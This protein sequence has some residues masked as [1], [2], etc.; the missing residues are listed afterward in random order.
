MKRWLIAATLV[1]S[2]AACAQVLASGAAVVNGVRISQSDVDDEVNAQQSGP[3]TPDGKIQIARQ[4]LGRLIQQQ[5]LLQEAARR[6]IVA[7]PAKVKE[8]FDQ[9]AGQFPTKKEFADRL[10]EFGLTEDSL[11]ARIRDSLMISEL[12]SRLTGTISNN[13]LLSI[14]RAE[15]SQYRQV[16]VKHILFAV[17]ERHP[18][19]AAHDAAIAAREKILAGASFATLA[20]KSDDTSS[21]ATGGALPG[22]TSLAQ[23]DP[24]FAEAAWTAKPGVVTRPVRSQFGWHLIVTTARRIQPFAEVKE[25]IRSQLEQQVTQT[26]QSNFLRAVVKR[27]EI[28]VNPRYGDWDPA[29]AS[30]VAHQSFVPPENSIDDNAPGG[31]SDQ[32]IPGATAPQ[33][34]GEIKK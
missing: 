22:W 11:R 2:T 28:I 16:R 7:N 21:R 14:Y 26:A 27:A 32:S 12:S 15:Q 6:R 5:L 29:S 17:D 10:K 4:V 25:Q 18:D 8:Q 3:Q 19:V 30:V 23:L 34:G 1:L 24:S 33:S 13:Q 31:F 9:I 20:K